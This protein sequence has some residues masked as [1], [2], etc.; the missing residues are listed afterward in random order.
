MNNNTTNNKLKKNFSTLPNAII[1]DL[2]VEATALRVYCYLLSKPD[3]WQV[4]NAEIKKSV[5]IKSDET[6][7]K[8]WKSLIS[9]GWVTRRRNIDPISR[10]LTGG[11]TYELNYE[12]EVINPNM[13]E[14]HIGEKPISGNNPNMEEVPSI[15]RTDLINNNDIV[16]NK[17]INKK[18]VPRFDCTGFTVEVM[19]HIQKWIDHKQKKKK[20]DQVGLDYLR[21]ELLEFQQDGENLIR[22]ISKALASNY[23][24]LFSMKPRQYQSKQDLR[25]AVATTHDVSQNGMSF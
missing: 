8:A 2:D 7:A 15:I 20:Y 22:I 5:G 4:W 23:A 9:A 14:V 12:K 24:G 6:I 3:N 16:N 25:N 18:E 21:N 17:K 13:E 19:V 11:L 10:K 1:T